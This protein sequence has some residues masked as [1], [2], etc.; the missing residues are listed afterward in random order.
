ML[1]TNEE[2][3][4]IYLYATET[5]FVKR[6][7]LQLSKYNTQTAHIKSNLVGLELGSNSLAEGGRGLTDY[8]KNTP[9]KLLFVF[10]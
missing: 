9:H 8:V 1:N 2:F 5:F 3:I 10:F 7:P 4:A 6:Q